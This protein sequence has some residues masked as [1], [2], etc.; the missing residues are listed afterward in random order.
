MATRENDILAHI[1]D[2]LRNH[3]SFQT[4]AD[5]DPTTWS[6]DPGSRSAGVTIVVTNPTVAGGR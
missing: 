3:P 2:P 1:I 5:S 4:L 6:T